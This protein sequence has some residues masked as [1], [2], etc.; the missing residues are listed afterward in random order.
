LFIPRPGLKENVGYVLFASVIDEMRFNSNL[1]IRFEKDIGPKLT[2]RGDV[3]ARVPD[4]RRQP[5]L[6]LRDASQDARWQ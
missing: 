6:P 4:V 5:S 1:M 2:D 3:C